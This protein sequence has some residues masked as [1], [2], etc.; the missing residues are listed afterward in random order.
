MP[1]GVYVRTEAHR[2]HMSEAMKGRM[3]WTF[4]RHHS[5][6]TKQ[7]ISVAN[8]GNKGWNKGLKGYSVSWNLG[9]KRSLAFRQ[10]HAGK[11]CH[12]WKGGITP[13][14]NLIRRSIAYRTWRK[15]VFERDDY[16][17]YDCGVKGVRMQ[18]HHI[19]A[20]STYP[21]LRFDIQNGITLCEE[22]HRKTP[23]YAL[24][25]AYQP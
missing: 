8:K 4:G 5:E 18:A 3:P 16:R 1:T 12:F 6:E 7:K 20:F 25:K 14:N 19:L 10:K 23:N 22:C 11:N 13:V 15:A 24:K 2:Q 17:C 21:R 9:R